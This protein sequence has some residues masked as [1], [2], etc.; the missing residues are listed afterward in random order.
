MIQLSN[1]IEKK[2]IDD[3]LDSRFAVISKR[4]PNDLL[5]E[6]ALSLFKEINAVFIN[7]S[8]YDFLNPKFEELVDTGDMIVRPDM[9]IYGITSN[10]VTLQNLS[11]E[12]FERL[13]K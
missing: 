6:S 3:L 5:D 4:D 11:D 1:K 8:K 10:E 7:V 13:L 2:S 12:L 9:M